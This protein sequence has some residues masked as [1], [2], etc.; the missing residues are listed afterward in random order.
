MDFQEL[1]LNLH[2]YWSRR[3]CL[4]AQPYD[5]E[6]GAGTFNPS[7]FLRA[8]GP[9]SYTHLTLP[10]IYSVSTQVGTVPIK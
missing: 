8:L 4:I 2:D 9:V 6:V 10:T 3:G 7:T 5:L 1:I